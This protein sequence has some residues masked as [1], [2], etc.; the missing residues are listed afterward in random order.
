[1]YRNCLLK[2]IKE[3]KKDRK[4]EVRIA[5]V[6]RRGRR[7]EQLLEDLKH[8]RRYSKLK[9]EALYCTLLRTQLVRG[10]GP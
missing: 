3:R 2:H 1:L 9:E 6:D 5:V 10:Y 4:K 8:T 7:H